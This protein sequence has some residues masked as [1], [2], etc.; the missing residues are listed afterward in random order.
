VKKQLILAMAA[1]AALGIAG[2][3]EALLYDQNVTSNQIQG[4]GNNNGGYTVDQAGGVELGLRGKLRHGPGGLPQNLF[5]SNGDGTYNFA[6]GVAPTQAYPTAIWS[7]DWS[8]NS[9]Y[10]E[11]S[12]RNL[13]DLSYR[14]GLDINPSQGVQFFSFDPINNP[15]PATPGGYWDHSIGDNSTGQSAGAEAGD[16]ATYN[17]LIAN[18]N[19]GQNS[20]KPHWYFPIFD[21][22][23]NGT[24]DI[25]LAAYDDLGNQVAR[26]AIQIIVGTGGVPVPEPATMT[27]LGLGLV[28]LA[29]RARKGMKK[30]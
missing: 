1:T 24:Y 10:L 22:T 30:S 25:Y 21:P 16:I 17:S 3:A 6:A 28:G 2:S 5:N 23:V 8:I 15:N 4:N 20:W 14:L 29:A 26:T 13:D 18:N 9:D 12:D 19:L 11:T 7:F 27:L